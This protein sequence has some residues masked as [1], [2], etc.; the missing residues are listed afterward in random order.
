LQQVAPNLLLGQRASILDLATFTPAT[1]AHALVVE[2]EE[3]GPE[4]A[5]LKLAEQ[6][7]LPVALQHANSG[8]QEPQNPRA[9]CD[10]LQA[11]AAP[12]GQ[13]AGYLAGK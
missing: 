1:W 7:G 5:R 9:A 3:K 13:F 4:L 2:M 6:A 10:A 11:A 12:F 8:L